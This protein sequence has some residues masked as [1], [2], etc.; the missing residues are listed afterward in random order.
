MSAVEMKRNQ[1]AFVLIEADPGKERHVME[2]LLE[3]DEVK[4]VHIYAGEL[5]LIAVLEVEREIVAPSSKIITDF[6]I[7]KIQS[8]AE[9]LDTETIM[10]TYSK[11]KWLERT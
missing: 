6:V 10:P 5:D 11:T 9:V 7:D 8:I 4:E 1:R 3:F 2:K